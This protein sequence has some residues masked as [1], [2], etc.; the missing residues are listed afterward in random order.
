[1]TKQSY[2][3]PPTI[4]TGRMGSRESMEAHIALMA[5]CVLPYRVRRRHVSSHEDGAALWQDK[6]TR[7]ARWHHRNL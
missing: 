2:T 5:P 3:T 1:M 6:A 4:A 7:L